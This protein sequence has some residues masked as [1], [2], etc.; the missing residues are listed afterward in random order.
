MRRPDRPEGACG[1][2]WARSSRVPLLRARRP[3]GLRGRPDAPTRGVPLADGRPA[4]PGHVPGRRGAH[5]ASRTASPTTS[6]A[7]IPQTPRHRLAQRRDGGHG[8]AV[9]GAPAARRRRLSSAA[10]GGPGRLPPGRSSPRPADRGRSGGCRGR[11]RSRAPA[12]ARRPRR[13]SLAAAARSTTSSVTCA[14]KLRRRSA[15]SRD[16]GMA[17]LGRKAAR[18]WNPSSRTSAIQAAKPAASSVIC[19]WTNVAPASS[20][21]PIAET[22]PNPGA[23]AAPMARSVGCA[24]QLAAARQQAGV[25]VVRE[26][27]EADGG[28]LAHLG[29]LGV[30][31]LGDRVAAEREDA[32]RAE[33]GGAEDLGRRAR[34]GCGRAP[35]S[36]GS[37]PRRPR[38]RTPSPPRPTCGRRR[39]P[40]R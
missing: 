19:V 18:S 12:A 27:D 14:P 26:L 3:A 7:H 16:E 8:G 24:V 25:E 36:A 40:R 1:R 10:G 37:A 17:M 34:S 4:R 33:R 32:L 23:A 39:R 28:Q 6:R 35:S 30:L 38:P 11:P 9:R 13:G 31:A 5:A 29:R 15:P 2:R 22:G 20:L 21:S